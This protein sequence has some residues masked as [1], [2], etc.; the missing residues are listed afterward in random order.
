MLEKRVTK[1]SPLPTIQQYYK[2][3]G[4][5]CR[6]STGIQ[7][8]LHSLASQISYFTQ[9]ILNRRGWLLHDFYIDVSCGAKM[10]GRDAFLRMLDD[11]KNQRVD[12]I[13]TKSVSRFGRN[14]EEA[15]IALRELRNAGVEIIFEME[16]I[17]T[18]AGDSE[19]MISILESV[20]QA[21]NET[22]SEDIRWG[23]KRRA[24]NGTSGFFRRR[25]YGYRNNK[26]GDLEIFPDEAATIRFIFE[27]Y[28]NGASLNMIQRGLHERGTPSPTGKETWCKRSIDELLSNEKYCGDVMLMKTFRAGGI[29]SKRK[30]NDGQ[31]D[32]YLALSNHPLI[33]DKEAFEA[34]QTEKARRSN[35]ERTEAGTKRKT[36][37]YSA[38]KG[39]SEEIMS[40]EI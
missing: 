14:T 13:I 19:Q 8:Q 5:Y 2:R 30:R 12:T 24:A 29:G 36:E 40:V 35:I 27:A 18:S 3:V 10:G 34:V 17:Y 32:K 37:R 39:M 26:N 28:L 11:C 1:L 15:L 22:R 6:V 23:N 31:A 33:I 21:E 20:A 7:E 25:C 4:V 38:K 16:D 9:L